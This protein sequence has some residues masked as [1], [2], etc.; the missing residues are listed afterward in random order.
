[1]NDGAQHLLGEHDFRNLCKM[2]VNN[3]VVK[4]VRNVTKVSIDKMDSTNNFEMCVFSIQG[5]A[6]LWHQIRAIMSIL[7]LIGE[8]KE[9]PDIIRT[10]LDIEEVPR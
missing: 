1:M 8:K 10:L 4:F 3:G 9:D 7:I 2:D 6:F 5:K